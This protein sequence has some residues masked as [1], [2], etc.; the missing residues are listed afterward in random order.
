[1]QGPA[2]RRD[3]GAVRSSPPQA[4]RP[5]ARPTPRMPR[6]G[7]LPVPAQAEFRAS[8]GK[9]AGASEESAAW[10][11]SSGLHRL[12]SAAARMRRRRRPSA[13]AEQRRATPAAGGCSVLPPR[14]RAARAGRRVPM[15]SECGRPVPAPPDNTARRPAHATAGARSAR[16]SGALC[17]RPVDDDQLDIRRSCGARRTEQAEALM[18]PTCRPGG[19]PLFGSEIYQPSAAGRTI[20]CNVLDLP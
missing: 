1:M 7:E 15:R 10:A 3:A 13:A 20:A 17:T 18:Q 8:R 12:A 16:P 9:T 19:P 4:E 6:I 2:S 5:A 11:C 14:A